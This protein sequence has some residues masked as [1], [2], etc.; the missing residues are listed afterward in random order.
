MR[1]TPRPVRLEG[2]VPF[3]EPVRLEGPV[4]PEGLAAVEE[5][6]RFEGEEGEGPT[7]PV[8]PSAGTGRSAERMGSIPHC[9]G[10]CPVG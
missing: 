10:D 8:D 5:P 6:V 4:R 9:H 7:E 1:L 3:E 2:L